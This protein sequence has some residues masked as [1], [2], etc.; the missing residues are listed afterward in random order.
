MPRTKIDFLPL[1]TK[2]QIG[3]PLPAL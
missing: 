2:L 3:S 1:I